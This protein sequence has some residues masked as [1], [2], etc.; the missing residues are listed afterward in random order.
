MV[1][2]VP[3]NAN[4]DAAVEEAVAIVEAR[5]VLRERIP[6]TTDNSA[7]LTDVIYG[8]CHE[9]V[10]PFEVRTWPFVPTVVRPVPPFAVGSA[11][12]E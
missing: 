6:E 2:A 1:S 7:A 5:A 9:S 12:P 10:A 4:A 8:V 3:A 11:V